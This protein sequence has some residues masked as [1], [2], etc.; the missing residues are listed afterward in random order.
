MA[1]VSPCLWFD[2]QAEEAAKFY[3]SVVPNSRIIATT[4]YNE[5]VDGD[6][7]LTITT[8]GSTTSAQLDITTPRSDVAATVGL[9]AGMTGPG[10]TPATGIDSWNTYQEYGASETNPTLSGS[11]I[12]YG[13]MG[14]QQRAT[15]DP[16]LTLMGDRLYNS[17]TGQFTSTDPVF[18]GNST[19]YTYPQDP[20][21]NSD[22]DGQWGWSWS[23]R[24]YPTWSP[25]QPWPIY[26]WGR[27]IGNTYSQV[28]RWGYEGA[29]RAVYWG[30]THMSGHRNFSKRNRRRAR[31]RSGQEL[32]PE[33]KSGARPSTENR[34]QEGKARGE[35]DRARSNNPNK[36]RSEK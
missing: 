11:G 10:A 25:F 32:H 34:H 35:R 36:R 24:Y 14:G 19:P 29:S 17:E 2:N 27:Q 21:D 9:D 30:V 23:R 26:D 1:G 28:R 16:G 18:G 6:L 12:S 5:L 13:W 15:T 3:V 33:H 4:R 22:P 8:T 20:I 31:N 7:G